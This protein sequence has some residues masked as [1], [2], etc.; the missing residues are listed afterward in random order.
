MQRGGTSPASRSTIRISDRIAEGRLTWLRA[1]PPLSEPARDQIL[2]A[3]SEEQLGELA[4]LLEPIG[5]RL[6]EA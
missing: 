5:A 3:L 4:A 1:T 6:E 2:G